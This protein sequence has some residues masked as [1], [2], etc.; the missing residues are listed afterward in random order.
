MQPLAPF[1]HLPNFSKLML[2]VSFTLLAIVFSGVVGVALISK[3]YTIN[4]TGGIQPLVDAINEQL[5][6]VNALKII[7][8][9]YQ[10]I[11]F[12][13]PALFFARLVNYD[14][15]QQLGFYN[16]TNLKSYLLFA[17][18]PMLALPFIGYISFVSQQLISTNLS[19]E[20]QSSIAVGEALNK[21]II[22][23]FL[24]YQTPTDLV[25][26]FI[27]ICLLPAIAE[28]LL[29]RAS[30]QPLLVK[31]TRNHHVGIFIT[32]LIFGLIHGELTPLIARVSLGL[33]LGY[34]YHYTKTI[35]VP[36]IGHLLNNAFTLW[37][38]ITGLGSQNAAPTTAFETHITALPYAILSVIFMVG[39]IYILFKWNKHI[40]T[41]EEPT[42]ET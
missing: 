11:G 19:A 39:S 2:L 34:A 15:G 12:I 37:L 5:V 42:D 1:K 32:A 10:L 28:E 27:V 9:L 41:A 26:T 20:I 23:L 36:I 7:Q 4:I 13:L 40:K 8:L 25:F 22:D 17:I 33:C 31:I 14:V 18:V 30:L 16:K 3:K 6:S 38:A 29:F 21:N 35:W 24:N